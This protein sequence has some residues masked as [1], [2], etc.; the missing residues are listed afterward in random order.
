MPRLQF[1]CAATPS[2]GPMALEDRYAA[3]GAQFGAAL[4]L[5]ILRYGRESSAIYF[6]APNGLERREQ[7]FEHGDQ[8]F[9]ERLLFWGK[10][11]HTRE[12]PDEVKAVHDFHVVLK[13]APCQLPPVFL[14]ATCV[15]EKYSS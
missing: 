10:C 14:T 12:L 15:F 4:V 3:P 2:A 9:R 5:N 8:S 7:C 6:V 11:L 13:L 1:V